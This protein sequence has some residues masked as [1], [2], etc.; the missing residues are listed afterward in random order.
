[1]LGLNMPG[2]AEWIVILIIA[3]LLFGDRLPKVMRSLGK[4]MSEFK[5]GMNEPMAEEKSTPAESK[6][7]LP[8][9]QNADQPKGEQK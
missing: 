2:G 7:E 5:R 1:M 4:S 6:A 8:Q 3:L 9:G